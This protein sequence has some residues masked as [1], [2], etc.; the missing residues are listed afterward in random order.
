MN[1]QSQNSIV[2]AFTGD[3]IKNIL[4]DHIKRVTPGVV[5]RDMKMVEDGLVFEDVSFM[6]TRERNKKSN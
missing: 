6:W 4:L 1:I 5:P 2:I 3:E